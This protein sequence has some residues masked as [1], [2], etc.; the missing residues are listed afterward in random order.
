VSE[1]VVSGFVP[2]DRVMTLT[3]MLHW[4]R[5]GDLPI[6]PR[7]MGRVIRADGFLVGVEF[8][9]GGTFYIP[10]SKLALVEGSFLR[11]EPDDEREPL[12]TRQGVSYGDELPF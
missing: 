10:A 4:T 1:S 3:R 2:G 5:K 6:A 12:D 7:T 11:A 8:E 9:R